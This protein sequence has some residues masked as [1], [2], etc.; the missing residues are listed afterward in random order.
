MLIWR[1]IGGV[2]IIVLAN[3]LFDEYV[4]FVA[5]VA[6]AL[7]QI[8]LVQRSRAIKDAV[9]NQPDQLCPIKLRIKE[10]GQQTDTDSLIEKALY[11]H[12]WFDSLIDWD[13]SAQQNYGSFNEMDIMELNMNLNVIFDGKLPDDISYTDAFIRVVKTRS[14]REIKAYIIEALETGQLPSNSNLILEQQK[15]SIHFSH[16][17]EPNAIVIGERLGNLPESLG[18]PIESEYAVESQVFSFPDQGIQVY[19]DAGDLE[20]EH[21]YESEIKAIRLQSNFKGKIKEIDPM[22]GHKISAVTIA[23]GL[24]DRYITASK[25]SHKYY[26]QGLTFL[27]HKLENGDFSG[28][29]D[30][31]IIERI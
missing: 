4:A 27:E 30:E 11:Q 22:L 17:Q 9:K 3:L 5:V 28:L 19:F 24:A 15:R 25:R 6:Y 7:L 16:L 29:V 13:L 23:F 26:D 1:I 8:Y 12:L 18:D 2:L 21:L 10:L 14:L 31:V 20:E